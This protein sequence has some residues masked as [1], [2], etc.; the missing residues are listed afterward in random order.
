MIRG[1]N[2]AHFAENRMFGKISVPELWTEKTKKIGYFQRLTEKSPNCG[3]SIFS[4][5]VA[6]ISFISHIQRAMRAYFCVDFMWTSFSG[7]DFMAF[8]ENGSKMVQ[9]QRNLD[10]FKK[11]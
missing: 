6:R 3:F 5:L 1:H 8:L 4:S 11:I 10:I 9:N 2:C 7:P